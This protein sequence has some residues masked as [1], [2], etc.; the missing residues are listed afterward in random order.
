MS[1]K[2]HITI[3]WEMRWNS[4]WLLYDISP[5]VGKVY[6]IKVKWST[7][8]GHLLVALVTWASGKHCLTIKKTGFFFLLSK[9]QSNYENNNT[10]NHTRN[11]KTADS[12]KNG[13][14]NTQAH[15][16]IDYYLKFHTSHIGLI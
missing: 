10:N 5:L 11:N 4:L 7:G 16:Y 12:Q 6:T 13:Q 1:L 14:L 15:S 2:A 3:F 8:H 9:L